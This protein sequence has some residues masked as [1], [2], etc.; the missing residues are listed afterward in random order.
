MGNAWVFPSIS[1]NMGKCSKTHC[2]GRTWEISNH[3]FPIVWIVFP[4]RFPYHGILHHMGN[5]W[6]F[7]QF[8]IV[9]ENETKPIVWGKP[10]KLVIRLF[11]S[12]GTFFPLDPDPMVYFII[13]EIRGFSHQFPI[14][15]ENATK[16][17][18]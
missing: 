13:W 9:R 2:M 5:A 8:P 18:L 12:M 10:G 11:H 7:H 4:I 14:V 6:V 15:R 1:H 17:I 3:T 16:P